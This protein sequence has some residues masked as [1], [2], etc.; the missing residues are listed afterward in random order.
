[1]MSNYIE[2]FLPPY[3]HNQDFSPLSQVWLANFSVSSHGHQNRNMVET[4]KSSLGANQPNVSVS[5]DYTAPGTLKISI[6]SKNADGGSSTSN[7][8]CSFG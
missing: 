7:M 3:I 5:I 4:V 1:M 2:R 6:T 8:S